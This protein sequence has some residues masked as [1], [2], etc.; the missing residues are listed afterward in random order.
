MSGA[1]TAGIGSYFGAPGSIALGK[2]N[3]LTELE[4]AGAHALA[5]GTGNVSDLA[6]SK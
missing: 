5:Q 2:F 1:I 3:P 4:R 6:L